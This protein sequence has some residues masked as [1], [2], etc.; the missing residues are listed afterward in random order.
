M[1]AIINILSTERQKEGEGAKRKREDIGTKKETNEESRSFSLDLSSS[2]P[3]LSS[4]FSPFHFLF[5]SLSLSLSL[6]LREDNSLGIGED[7]ED[8]RMVAGQT[9]RSSPIGSKLN[10]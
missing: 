10:S 5:L 2:F 3:Y 1:R 4:L 7:K 6:F 9:E 8:D